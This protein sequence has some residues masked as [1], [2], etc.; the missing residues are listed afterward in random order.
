MA[1][2]YRKIK[3]TSLI[4]VGTSLTKEWIVHLQYQE[5][6]IFKS[7][8]PTFMPKKFAEFLELRL[9]SNVLFYDYKLGGRY[10]VED[11]FT[12]NGGLPIVLHLG[13][14]DINNGMQL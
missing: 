6:S 9:D 14:W 7:D 3:P 5:P 1:T 8:V 12:V 10:S 2:L 13:I 4:F 11:I